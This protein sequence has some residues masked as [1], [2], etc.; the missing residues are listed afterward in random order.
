MIS[1]QSFL[2]KT[3]VMIRL[4]QVWSSHVWLAE[5]TSTERVTAPIVMSNVDAECDE[6]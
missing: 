4:R 1:L 3:V 6:L 5:T 2:A